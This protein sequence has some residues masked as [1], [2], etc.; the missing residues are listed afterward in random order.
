[1]S[2]AGRLQGQPPTLEW[3]ATERLEVDESYQRA[4]DGAQSRR[5]IV[6]MVKC[7]D[8]RLCQ[9]LNVSRRADGRMFVVDGQHRLA[10][11]RER[12]DLP[13]LPCVVTA[14]ADASE[15]AHTFVALN[16][17]RQKL[18]QG[19]VFNAMLSA[20]DA[21]AIRVSKLV[22][23]VGLSFARSHTPAGWKPGEL[24]CGPALVKAMRAYGEPVVADA[25]TALAQA[26]PDTVMVRAATLLNALTLIYSDDAQRPGFDPAH[27]IVAL[28]SIAQLDWV[29]HASDTREQRGGAIS[30]RDALAVTFMEQYDALR[31]R[32]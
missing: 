15:E 22:A 16:L 7:W 19:D 20:G 11:A 17:K 5:I 32:G 12:G 10:G 9:P 24:F 14:H 23:G 3:I 8:W 28:G 2:A 18:S 1:M 13:Y 6:G 21:D 4:T 27:F 31:D 25:L 30:F 29:G 26:Y